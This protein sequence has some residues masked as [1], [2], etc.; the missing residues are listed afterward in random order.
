M[1]GNA[2]G[3]GRAVKCWGVVAWIMTTWT[4]DSFMKRSVVITF[5]W[6][7]GMLLAGLLLL[8]FGDVLQSTFA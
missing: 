2:I 3:P 7:V 1:G 8:Q 4:D 6:L 5:L